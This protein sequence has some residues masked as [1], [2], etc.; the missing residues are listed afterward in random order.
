MS[1]PQPVNRHTSSHEIIEL[2]AS[3][4][5]KSTRVANYSDERLSRILL[6]R[7]ADCGG[8]ADDL[9]LT[10]MPTL[11]DEMRT[12][13]MAIDSNLNIIENNLRDCEV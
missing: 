7:I 10:P 12:M 11:F 4:D 2:L 5:E 1:Q 6:R 8:T 13:L 3:L 9:K